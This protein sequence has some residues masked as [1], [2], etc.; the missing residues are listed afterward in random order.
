MLQI[1][2][3]VDPY[4][5]SSAALLCSVSVLVI[6]FDCVKYLYAT[7]D[8]HF[9]KTK[10]LHPR[11]KTG[12]ISHPFLPKKTSSLQRPISSVPKVA[13][14]GRLDCISFLVCPYL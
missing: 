3:K 4:C 12:V 11:V 5:G 14:A 6:Y 13:V 10:M 7:N 9:V 8:K 2:T 1:M